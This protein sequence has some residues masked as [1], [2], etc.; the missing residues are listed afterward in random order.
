MSLEDK[1]QDSGRSKKDEHEE[2]KEKPSKEPNKSSSEAEAE[3][4][5]DILDPEVLDDLPPKF[6]REFIREVS[7]IRSGSVANPIYSKINEDHITSIIT[8]GAESNK[9]DFEDAQRERY[10]KFAIV[11][12]GVGLFIFITLYLA[13]DNAELF[14]NILVGSATFIG[15][16]GVGYG[17]RSRQSR[18]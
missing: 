9:R 10:F 2:D 13:R 1:N 6:K 5:E 8:E 12:V 4:S 3:E 16:A 18:N 14:T 7:M 17:Y 11:L 15:G